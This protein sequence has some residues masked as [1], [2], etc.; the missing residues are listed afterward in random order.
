MTT[1]TNPQTHLATAHKQ[2]P[3]RIGL[4]GL[5]TVGTGV[6]KMLSRFENV[7]IRKI[8]VK[9][10][11][12][13]RQ[14]T[15][16][17][18]DILTESVESVVSDP[19]IDLIVEVMGGKEF[20]YQIIKSALAAGKHVVTANK[21]VIANYGDELFQL[22]SQNGVNLLF[23]AAVAGGIPIVLPL[24]TS[25]A[26]NR[27]QQIAGILNGTTNYILTRM[28]QAGLDFT[29]ALK[30]AQ[31][32]GFAEAD[33]TADVEGHDA[34]CKIA[35]LSAISCQKQVDQAAI[36]TEGI[37]SIGAIDIDMARELGYA[38][39]LIALYKAG[40][41]QR[42]DIR[43]HPMLIPVSHPLSKIMFEN[44]A[45]WVK[46][47]AVGDVMFYGK[48]AGELPT[49]SA[50]VGDIFL[51]VHA[52]Q[53]GQTSLAGLHFNL[54]GKASPLPMHDTVN[55]YYIR[56]ETQD[57]AGVIGQ[58]GKACGEHGVSLTAVMQKG[59]DPQTQ[60]ATIVLLTHDVQE[61]NLQAALK[62]MQA[63]STTRKIHTVLR[64]FQP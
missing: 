64:V 16:I 8:A 25:L 34:A 35:I 27:I 61:A 1:A 62:A 31:Q 22:A 36:H 43:V 10:I 46:G 38:I 55:A 21:V 13:Q 14:L 47:D 63:Q 32:M 17:P 11:T 40:E 6:Y 41:D 48:G 44:N 57:E 18:Q 4:L 12:K 54:E 19:D 33:P 39:R 2:T 23:E 29:D 56:L 24:R 28:E 49:A 30:E 5:G 59:I 7:T 51:L 45:I 50:V 60:S 52:L 20:P 9:D 37:S 26:G 42:V 15:E 58:L 3:V 53:N